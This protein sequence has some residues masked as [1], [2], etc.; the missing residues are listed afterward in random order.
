VLI[1]RVLMLAYAMCTWLRRHAIPQ[2]TAGHGNTRGREREKGQNC[3][4]LSDVDELGVMTRVS[5]EL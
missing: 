1:A 4:R 2:S 3:H 5:R